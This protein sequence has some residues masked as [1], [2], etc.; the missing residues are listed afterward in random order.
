MESGSNQIQL[1]FNGYFNTALLWK[2]K[3]LF[4][5]EQLQLSGQRAK[6]IN[7]ILSD[8][9]RLGNRVEHF[10][11]EEL[12]Q[13]NQ[14]EVLAQNTQIQNGKITIG[15]LD[16]ILK[17]DNVPIHLEIVYKFY[18]Y[19]PGSGKNEIDHWIGPNRNDSLHQKLKKLRDKQLPLID[20]DHSRKL[21]NELNIDRAILKQRVLFKAQLF[22]P[23]RQHI[24]F[25]AL[26]KDCIQ[27]FYIHKNDV[28]QFSDCEFYIPKKED[29][30][31]EIDTD[32]DWINYEQFLARTEALLYKK[33]SP[34]SWIKFPDGLVQKFFMV[35]W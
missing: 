23:Y 32:R 15:E 30:L 8:K 25:E 10:V 21:L 14:I 31:L 28:E 7:L 2:D 11:F 16:C 6:Q 34:L 12:K 1:Q 9:I 26:N 24:I 29:W 27:G 35:W 13:T 5:M 19:D 22:A 4:G 17:Q 20:H 3:P 18:L 33:K